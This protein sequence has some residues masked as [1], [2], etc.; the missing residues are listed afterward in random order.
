MTA[1][2]DSSAG[3]AKLRCVPSWMSQ[4]GTD[5][6]SEYGGKSCSAVMGFWLSTAILMNH[7]D[8]EAQRIQESKTALCYSLAVRLSLFTEDYWQNPNGLCSALH[9]NK[10]LG[11]E[12]P[13]D[14]KNKGRL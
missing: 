6:P 11:A 2:T 9:Q 5:P 3:F 8:P 1:A 7:R 10:S 12:A 4:R 13:R 14:G